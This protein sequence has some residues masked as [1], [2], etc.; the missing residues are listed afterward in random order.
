VLLDFVKEGH[1]MNLRMAADVRAMVQ[2][3]QARSA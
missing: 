1:Q 3:R 2:E